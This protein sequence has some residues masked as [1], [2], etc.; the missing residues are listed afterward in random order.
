ME[1]FIKLL[2]AIAISS[3]AA[4][5]SRPKLK[6]P[7]TPV[8]NDLDFPQAKEGEELPKVFGTKIIK[9]PRVAW[10]GDLRTE[11]ITQRGAR[12]YGLFGPRSRVT[13]GF[14]YSIGIHFV[15]G[16]GPM[17]RVNSIFVDG[18]LAWANNLPKGLF[19]I[20]QPNLFGPD[21]R[22][23]G[24]AGFGRIYSGEN[25]QTSS[26]FQYLNSKTSLPHP[27]Y[28]GVFSVVMEQTYV[29]NA[30]S[31]RPW[32]F[33]VTRINKTDSRYNEGDQWNSSKAAILRDTTPDQ[34]LPRTIIVALDASGS[35]D[36]STPNGN[37][38]LENAKL[39]LSSFFES[40]KGGFTEKRTLSILFFAWK[41]A[42]PQIHNEIFVEAAKESDIDAVIA[43]LQSVEASGGTPFDAPFQRVADFVENKPFCANIDY[44]F[45]TDGQPTGGSGPPAAQIYEQNLKGKINVLGISI[46]TNISAALIACT[47]SQVFVGGGDPEQLFVATAETSSLFDM[48]AVHI[49]R[50]VLLS[51]DAA[52]NLS[53]AD[54]GTTWD[55]AADTAFQEGFGL[56][57]LWSSDIPRGEFISEIENHLDAR[58][59][60]DRATGKWD[61]KLIRNDYDS[62][63]L[64]VFDDTNVVNWQRINFPEEST[65]PNQLVLNYTKSEGDE[66][67]SL[68]ISNVAKIREND[69]KVIQDEITFAG[70]YR[71]DLA[72][73]VAQRELTARSSPL[74]TGEIVVTDLPFGLN[75][76]DPVI[77]HNP[78][79][80]LNNVVVRLVEIET[81]F[82]TESTAAIRFIQDKFDLDPVGFVV[83]ENVLP[84]EIGFPRPVEEFL[85]EE[86]P[87]GL[88]IQRLGLPSVIQ[89]FQQD[90]LAGF[91][92]IAVAAPDPQQIEWIYSNALLPEVVPVQQDTLPFVE[93][94][95]LLSQLEQR[96]DRNRIVLSIRLSQL[97][98]LVGQI[99]L[100]GSE[101]LRV[102]AIVA[103][104][105][106]GTSEDYWAPAPWLPVVNPVTVDVS[107]GWFDTPPEFHIAGEEVWLLRDI[108]H[109]DDEFRTKTD[110][111][112]IWAQSIA[113]K[114]IWPIELSSLGVIEFEERAALPLPVGKLQ[115]DGEFFAPIWEEQK[116]YEITW[117]HRTRFA[118][119][120]PHTS[121]GPSEEESGTTYTVLIEALDWSGN[122]L[123]TLVSA[124]VGSLTSY[125]YNSGTES[126]IGST[127]SWAAVSAQIIS[128]LDGKNSREGAS[129]IF[130]MEIDFDDV[131][132][133]W[134]N[135]S[136]ASTVFT[137][138]DQ[139]VLA[140]NGDPVGAILDFGQGD[141]P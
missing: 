136:D 78:R 80:G 123:E 16:L 47:D 93:K 82:T 120:L 110:E 73:R 34:D 19:Q 115:V 138:L 58:V 61:V 10:F 21:D 97:A 104:N 134:A 43:N 90:P 121:D 1:F 44:F 45:V 35:M 70:I 86:A 111:L 5:L 95:L 85:L 105:V 72:S 109:V 81:S 101:Y 128:T 116:V 12:A 63:L 119:P 49:L 87:I 60:V 33:R 28:R 39:A 30:P 22:E 125:S 37:T 137:S 48:N 133:I 84:P 18:R 100:V 127:D 69:G 103:L 96:A 27:A 26:E 141:L 24:V 98:G 139:N 126:E 102:E 71:S 2:I 51:P 79:L 65:L 25:S 106:F 52:G 38:R 140:Q 88:L 74:I 118:S 54:L 75:V 117:E 67:A 124:N 31:L 77:L 50:E 76:G 64:D 9:S 3:V 15:L 94:S 89:V 32:A 40:L 99:I 91:A 57:L 53:P 14:R 13:V 36:F 135:P 17:D 46:D 114:G 108:S 59:Y 132:G 7:P 20:C 66:T 122:V 131:P 6:P 113:S 130:P 92:H 23:G 107:R 8:E 68:T 29:G 55:A 41:S 4:Y 62:E 42:A 112:E 11:A 129:I 56:S 83:T